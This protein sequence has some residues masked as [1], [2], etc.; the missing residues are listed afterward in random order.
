M[1]GMTA[2]TDRLPQ[3]LVMIGETAY[4]KP[5][6][7]TCGACRSPY[8]ADIDQA[9]AEGYS[10]KMVRSLFAGRRPACPNDV[11]LRAHVAYGHL[12]APH[13]KARLA[14]E[15]SVAGRGGDSSVTSAGYEEALAAIIQHGAGLLASGLL[16]VRASDM[17]AAARLQAQIDRARD[18]EGVEASVWQAAFMNFFEIV[19]KH[20]SQ[21]QW[22]AF[23]AD[24]Y[25]SPEIRAVLSDAQRS[26]AP[27]EVER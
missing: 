27:G 23:V 7:A 13:L 3:R 26:V 17:V 11:I 14:V 6:D 15:E 16:E 10:Y 4:E 2:R 22:K 9:L 1:T 8:A 19:R 5:F 24:A 25:S 18:G 12:A 20:M 21:N